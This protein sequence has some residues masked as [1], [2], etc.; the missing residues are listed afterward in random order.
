MWLFLSILSA[1]F[2]GCYDVFKKQSLRQNEVVPVL[3]VSVFISC[4]ILTVPLMLSVLYPNNS[5]CLWYVEHVPLETHLWILLKSV[6]VLSSWLLAYFAM[7]NLPIT[8]VSPV[9]ATRPILTMLGALFLFGETLNVRQSLGVGCI[10]CSF[11]AFSVIGKKEGIRFFRNGWILCLIMAMFLGA[12]SGLYDKY[13][14]KRYDHNA[15]QVY[16]TYYQAVMMFFICL[17]WYFRNKGTVRFKWQWSMV[18]ISVF[19]I[20][21]D[22]VY[23]LALTFAGSLLA[24]VS[25]IRRTG[26]IVPFV[27]GTVVL[28]EKNPK[29]KALCLAGILL[30]MLILA[31]GTF[32]V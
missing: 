22:F 3:T 7:K 2:L 15:V 25:T 14:M 10:L 18:F 21:S 27:Y 28:K 12:A 24:V 9:N 32:F 17:V 30:G 4:I 6:L 8:I 26:V 5:G 23:L 1:L 13:L 31:V 29:L 19:L 11:F 16:Y 20:A